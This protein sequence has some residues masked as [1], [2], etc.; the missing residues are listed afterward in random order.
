MKSPS[1]FWK[2]LSWKSLGQWC[3]QAAAR[4]GILLL[5]LAG[6]Y[7]A[8]MAWIY[9]PWFESPP[10]RIGTTLAGIAVFAAAW[11]LGSIAAPKPLAEPERKPPRRKQRSKR[12]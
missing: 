9:K 8:A 2:E 3:K 10:I 7:L 1:Q 6:V 5:Y 12:R 11:Y 4:S